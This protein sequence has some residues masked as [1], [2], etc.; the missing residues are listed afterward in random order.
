MKDSMNAIYDEDPK[1]PKSE[2]IDSNES[3]G[4]MPK[5]GEDKKPIILEGLKRDWPH[6]YGLQR[7][8]QL[9]LLAA[10]GC[11]KRGLAR[12]LGC[13]PVLI[14]QLIELSEASDDEKKA[15]SS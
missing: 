11:S 3:A 13:S 7:G 12:E 6:L 14:R 2:T 5:N 4:T 15:L 10:L 8:E 1:L 9:R